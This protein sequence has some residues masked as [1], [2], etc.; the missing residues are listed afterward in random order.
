VKSSRSYPKG[1][2]QGAIVIF[3]EDRIQFSLAGFSFSLLLH[4]ALMIILY[5][6]GMTISSGI[7]PKA[8]MYVDIGFFEGEGGG[9]GLPGL[10]NNQ[11]A[12]V[13]VAPLSDVSAN[14]QSPA[15]ATPMV[16]APIPSQQNA[17]NT[18]GTSEGLQGGTGLP[19]GTGEGIGTGFGN[20][21]GSGTGYSI[22]WG[23]QGR[24][25]ILGYELPEY[26]T[27]VNKEADIRIL[28][29]ILV[30]GSVGSTVIVNKADTRL[31]SAALNSLRRWRFEPLRQSQAQSVQKVVITFPFRL[32]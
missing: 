17:V 8:A 16:E 4:L 6:L 26:P 10:N 12:T 5:Q 29:T 13:P 7:V 22:D 1:Y 3:S 24:R 11:S 28:F 25:R 31:E 15:A 2:T 30:D 9:S 14:A 18:P 20:G 27:G 32:R 23:G 21:I 19:T